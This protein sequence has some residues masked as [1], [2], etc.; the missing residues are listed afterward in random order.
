RGKAEEQRAQLRVAQNG[1]RTDEVAAAE[2]EVSAAEAAYA[3]AGWKVDQKTQNAPAAADVTDVLYREGE[4]VPAGSPVVTLLPS[5]NIKARFFVP[6]LKLGAIKLGQ[7]VT[8]QCDGCGAP[9]NGTVSFIAREAEYTAPIIYSKENRASLVF[10]IEAR[11]DPDAAKRLHP[12]QPLE[13]RL[14]ATAPQKTE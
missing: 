3:Q 9:I 12:G 2:K 4:F 6:E 11:P 13:L 7:P 14:A 1:A 8:I 10:M 5:G